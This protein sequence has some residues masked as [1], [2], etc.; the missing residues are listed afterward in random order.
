MG[1]GDWRPRKARTPDRCGHRRRARRN[2]RYLRARQQ[3]IAHPL[4]GLARGLLLLSLKCDDDLLAGAHLG[5]VMPERTQRREDG[6]ALR[7]ADLGLRPHEHTRD[8]SHES[9][10]PTIRLYASR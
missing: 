4:R 7:V 8:E 3:L 9:S 5:D 6:L 2:R 1:D 10:F